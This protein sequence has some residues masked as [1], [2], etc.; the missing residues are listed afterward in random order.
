MRLHDIAHARAGDKGDLSDLSLIA[1][2]AA[3][4]D[5]LR[6]EV[7]A[8]RVASHFADLGV[9]DVDR[10][11]VPQLGALKF[12]LHAALGGGVTR[13]LSLDA[14]GKA[15]SSALLELEIPDE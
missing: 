15:L 9:T 5:R 1:Y 12:V 11:E 3:D 13:S 7:T 8:D 4:Y 14:H 2:D 10:Y 6:D